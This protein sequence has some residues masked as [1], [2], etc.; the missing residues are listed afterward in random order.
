LS[1]FYFTGEQNNFKLFY[2][3]VCDSTNSLVRTLLPTYGSTGPVCVYSFEQRAGRGQG[4]N[5][6]LSNA[7]ENVAMTLAIKTEQVATDAIALNKLITIST[8]MAL[9]ELAGEDARIKWPNDILLRNLK[10]CGLLLETAR[11]KTD[12]FL[13]AG[14]GVNANQ[15]NWPPE[16]RA[17][18]LS[19]IAGKQIDLTDVVHKI[20]YFISLNINS[21]DN[22]DITKIGTAF[23]EYLWQRGSWLW[24]DLEEGAKVQGKI[25]EVDTL[26]RLVFEGKDKSINRLHHGQVRISKNNQDFL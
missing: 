11:E 3:P 16:F 6:W 17:V 2:A 7:G 9:S 12:Q 23:N 15:K 4:S 18:G 26:G 10:C 24:L 8:A 22:S 1:D 5:V 13:L 25:L 19:G 20:I 14:I 21:I